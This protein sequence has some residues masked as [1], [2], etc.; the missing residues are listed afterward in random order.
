M[1]LSALQAQTIDAKKY[2]GT[3]S[4]KKINNNNNMNSNKNKFEG[5]KEHVMEL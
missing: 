2:V 5:K 4:W 1:G 3:W